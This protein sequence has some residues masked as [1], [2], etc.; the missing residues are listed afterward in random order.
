MEKH[1]HIPIANG[2]VYITWYGPNPP[3]QEFMDAINRMAVKIINLPEPE[4]VKII[5]RTRYVTDSLSKDPAVIRRNMLKDL[6][7]AP[8]IND[9]KV[10]LGQ[11]PDKTEQ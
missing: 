5:E 10:I 6:G 11:V 3:S 1:T 4:L 2:Q 9:I 8:P 7:I